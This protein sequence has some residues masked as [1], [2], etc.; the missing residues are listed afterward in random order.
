MNRLS[1]ITRSLAAIGTGIALAFG[2]IVGTTPAVAN[3]RSPNFVTKAEFQRVGKGMKMER[4]HASFPRQQG[5]PSRQADL[6]WTRAGTT[7]AATSVSRQ[8]HARVG[9]VRGQ[10]P[11]HGAGPGGVHH[12]LQ[13]QRS[14]AGRQPWRHLELE[15]VIRHRAA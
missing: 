3:T 10:E 1:R 4:V 9:A 2:G 8:E 5:E 7:C 11:H 12:L 15:A 14:L 6:G 13:G